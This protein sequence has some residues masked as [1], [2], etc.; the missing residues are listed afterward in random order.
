LNFPC[1]A[2]PGYIF[3][4]VAVILTSSFPSRRRDVCFRSF[5]MIIELTV[6]VFKMSAA[7]L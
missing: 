6:F 3:F 5:G 4:F 7:S 1:F 2:E